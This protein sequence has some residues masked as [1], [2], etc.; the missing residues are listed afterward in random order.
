[1]TNSTKH[2]T[3]LHAHVTGTVLY[4]SPVNHYTWKQIASKMQDNTGVNSCLTYQYIN[5]LF[6]HNN[7]QKV[8]GNSIPTTRS[9]PQLLFLLCEIWQVLGH[10]SLILLSF[11]NVFWSDRYSPRKLQPHTILKITSRYY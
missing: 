3:G 9:L 8:T 6:N 10:C 4:H 7:P 11:N 5:S 1:M 2:I